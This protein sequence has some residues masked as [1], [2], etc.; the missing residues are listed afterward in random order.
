MSVDL[1]GHRSDNPAANWRG[2]TL[3]MTWWE[4]RPLAFYCFQIA[5]DLCETSHHVAK[6]QSNDGRMTRAQALALGEMIQ[7]E[8]ET[9]RARSYVRAYQHELENAPDV[10]C[11]LCKGT[12]KCAARMMWAWK[13]EAVPPDGMVECNGCNGYGTHRPTQC[14]YPLHLKDIQRLADFLIHSGGFE[15]R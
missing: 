14:N 4:W 1:V 7:A 13:P 9:G 5:P 3:S 10:P 12:G 6:W 11:L 15:V 8:I 2:T